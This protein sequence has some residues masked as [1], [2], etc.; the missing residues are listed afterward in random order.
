VIPIHKKDDTRILNNYR[1]IA[2]L[3][4]LSKFLEKL[5][6]KRILSF[7]TNTNVLNPHQYGFRPKHSTSDA[8]AQL[9]GHIIKQK[10]IKNS[11]LATFLDFSKAFDTIRHDTLHTKLHNLGIRGSARTLI[12]SYI[13]NRHQYTE[14]HNTRSNTIKLPPYGVPQGSILGPLLFIIYINDLHHTL[15]Y[16]KHLHYADDTTLY[17]TGTNTHTLQHHMNK[18]L[19]TLHKWCAANSLYLNAQKSKTVS[20]F[21]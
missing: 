3:P 19:D 8:I 12:E 6:A 15:K 5:I 7:V 2:L 21:Q 1:P 9:F 18:D 11:T 14:I 16:C 13:H 4:S 17:I 20:S 10:E